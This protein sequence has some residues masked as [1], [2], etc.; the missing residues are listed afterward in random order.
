MSPAENSK[1]PSGGTITNDRCITHIRDA[2]HS[3]GN[4]SRRLTL[5]IE[6][7]LNNLNSILSRSAKTAVFPQICI[8]FF[9]PSSSAVRLCNSSYSTYLHIQYRRSRRDTGTGCLSQ[10][11]SNPFGF[12]TLIT[13]K[14]ASTPFD[15]GVV[16]AKGKGAEPPPTNCNMGW[17]RLVGS[18][19]L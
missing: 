18:L 8:Y 3:E 2:V 5:K 7:E 6:L 15:C 11:K 12:P 19:K 9:E 14:I 4:S 13:D 16:F 10:A 17:L 1:P